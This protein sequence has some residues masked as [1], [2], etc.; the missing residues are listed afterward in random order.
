MQCH[1]VNHVGKVNLSALWPHFVVFQ[2]TYVSGWVLPTLNAHDP[3][4]VL[5]VVLVGLVPFVSHVLVLVCC[6]QMLPPHEV[7]IDS[8]IVCNPR[9]TSQMVGSCHLRAMLCTP[10]IH[11]TPL[12]VPTV[13]EATAGSCQTIAV[14]RKKRDWQCDR[15]SIIYRSTKYIL[16]TSNM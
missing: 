16:C 6:F 11:S 2:G 7:V 13:W 8:V 3:V 14:H 5:W 12:W 1:V 10:L 15:K 9:I 4:I